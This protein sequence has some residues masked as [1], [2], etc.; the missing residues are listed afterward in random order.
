MNT[1]F[2]DNKVSIDR[3]MLLLK[4]LNPSDD[5]Y[6]YL[7]D[8]LLIQVYTSYENFF[9]KMLVNLFTDAKKNYRYSP[10]LVDHKLWS[11]V[12]SNSGYI[13]PNGKWETMAKNF[14]LIKHCYFRES[15][16]F[17]DDL[18]QERNNFAHTGSHKLTVENILT[19]YEKVNYL[20]EYIDFCYTELNSESFSDFIKVQNFLYKIKTVFSSVTKNLPSNGLISEDMTAFDR[21]LEEFNKLDSDQIFLSHPK[22]GEIV[23]GVDLSFIL[24]C[25][26]QSAT[27]FST[28]LTNYEQSLKNI[29]GKLII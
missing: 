4:Q 8:E 22:V 13:V 20:C 21:I 25:K 7:R 26:G 11:I 28:H 18:V 24:N 5:V 2:K 19:A 10:F 12:E 23:H 29:F 17:I 15:K 9:K 14:P 16:V 6:E 3:I 27:E 1:V